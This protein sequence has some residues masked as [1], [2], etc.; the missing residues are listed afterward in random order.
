MKAFLL[1]LLAIPVAIFAQKEM[2]SYDTILNVDLNEVFVQELID[3]DSLEVKDYFTQADK[4]SSEYK[5]DDLD[6]YHLMVHVKIIFDFKTSREYKSIQKVALYGVSERG[7]HPFYWIEYPHF[8]DGYNDKIKG[9]LSEQ[10]S[11]YDKY[12]YSFWE[13]N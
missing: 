2:C 6:S 12:Y 13:I 7:R 1:I 3:K 5:T 8:P 11:I 10:T 9:L 4:L